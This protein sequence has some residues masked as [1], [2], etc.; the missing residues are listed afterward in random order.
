MNNI[1]NELDEFEFA[2]DDDHQHHQQQQIIDKTT[3]LD[4]IELKFI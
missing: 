1:I 4:K 3:T 2:I